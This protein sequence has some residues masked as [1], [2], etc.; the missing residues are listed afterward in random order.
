M[1]I[2]VYNHCF[3]TIFIIVYNP[4]YFLQSLLLFVILDTFYN[5]YHCL[6][7]ILLLKIFNIVYNLYN[8]LQS[9]IFFTIFI[10]VYNLHYCWKSSICLHFSWL[11]CLYRVEGCTA[12]MKVA[13][14]E[15]HVKICSFK[16][17]KYTVNQPSE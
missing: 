3:F 7:S 14:R 12:E 2:I 17:N 15:A 9:L 10:I 11:R 8:S 16:T 4:W 1:I 6:Q 5:L 13:D